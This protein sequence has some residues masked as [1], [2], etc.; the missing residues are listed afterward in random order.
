MLAPDQALKE[1]K[2]PLR[3]QKG[4][5][6]GSLRSNDLSFRAWH[7]IQRIWSLACRRE[8]WVLEGWHSGAI[9]SCS[10]AKRLLRSQM[11]GLH[12]PRECALSSPSVLTRGSEHIDQEDFAR[13]SSPSTEYLVEFVGPDLPCDGV[14]G[15][16]SD[17]QWQCFSSPLPMDIGTREQ[18]DWQDSVSW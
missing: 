11:S 16:W 1:E 5:E 3:Y 18:K 15:H 13:N 2:L 6:H 8:F 9:Y 14:Y 17:G 12:P 4:R 7:G 10:Q